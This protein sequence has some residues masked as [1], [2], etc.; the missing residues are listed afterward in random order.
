MDTNI[1][2]LRRRITAEHLPDELTISAVTLAEL[3]AGV[4]MVSGDD[5]A[6][7]AER[8]ARTALLQQVEHEFDPV[9]FGAQAARVF[10]RMSAAVL[11]SGRTPR[12]R[13]TDL[14]IAASA[15]VESLPLYTTNPGDFVGLDGLVTVVAVP[16]PTTPD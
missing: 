3:S 1:L 9:P 7:R 14:M 5:A 13:A 8:A 12:R 16:Y 4:H 6:A 15:A 11:A 10:G 2:I